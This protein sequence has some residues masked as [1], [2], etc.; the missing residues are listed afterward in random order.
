M[1]E[2]SLRR[3]RLRKTGPTFEP[4]PRLGLLL[5]VQARSVYN[6]SRQ[7]IQESPVR[8]ATA[9]ILV[10]LIWMGLY[11]LFTLVFNE[12]ERTPLEATVALP[13][14]FNFFFV[15]MLALLTFSNAIIVY[16][17]LY[18]NTESAYLLTSPLT[19]LDVVTLKY[20]ESLIKSSWSLILLGLPLMVSMAELAEKS[21]FYLLFLAFFIAF[22]PIPGA[23][24]LLL[25]WA[26]ARFFPKSALRVATVG[27]GAALAG[28]IAWGMHSLRLGESA[29]E[30]WLRS[31]LARMSF[32]E[33]AF[34][35]NHWVAA[36]IDHAIHDQFSESTLYLGVT[37]ANAFFLSWIAVMFVS[38]YFDVALDRVMSDR[39][40]E[41][42]TAARAS[43]G[44]AGLAF[45]YL[46]T[47]LRLIAAK[48]LRIFFRD[49]LQWSQLVILF[50]LLVLYLTNMPTLHL[51][52]GETVWSLIMPFLNLCAISLILATFTCRFVFPLVSLEG[53]KL[54]L[55][56][57]LPMPRAHILIAKFAFAM[58]VTL[59]VAVGA[60][61]LATTMLRLDQ[62]WATIHL[63][64]TIAICFGLC[65]LAVG[66]GA[67]LPMFDQSNV[68]RIANGL[69]GTANLL[70]SLALVAITLTGVGVATWRSRGL[71]GGALPDGTT[72][73]ICGAAILFSIAGGVTA[74]VVGARHFRCLE[75]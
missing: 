58:T 41:R 57:L 38:K 71:P 21:V 14:V 54:W 73:A 40:D 5:R 74:M 18:G 49:P 50:G 33:S 48:D 22:I 43:G 52:V 67:R 25:A 16:D 7:A 19:P 24:G 55:I 45:F 13:L 9:V 56:A 11:G 2:R 4:Q 47:P 36:G 60:T 39:A 27:A 72:L 3:E 46:S 64:A 20:L 69:G 12:F 61:V 66:I 34:L 65:G 17:A 37:I 32:V 53:Q 51:R 15:A 30:V 1:R 29:T 44:L 42:R 68:A 26:A 31:F 10:G 35:P 6:R 8:V 75:T 59:V 28:S 62:V 23:F 70:A 63:L